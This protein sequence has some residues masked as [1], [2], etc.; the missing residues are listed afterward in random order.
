MSQDNGPAT[1]PQAAPEEPQAEIRI[2]PEIN[3]R[4]GA[5]RG[6]V[7]SHRNQLGQ[8]EI[9]KHQ[10]IAEI[11]KL[12]AQAQGL[13]AHE[14]ERLGIPAQTPWALRP[15]GTIQFQGPPPTGPARVTGQ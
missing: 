9:Q 3:K 2:D 7:N 14:L 12:E 13:I 8:M 11:M 6:A 10:I 4:I 5:L 15:D 1:E